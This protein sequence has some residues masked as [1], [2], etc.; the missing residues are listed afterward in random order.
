M[1]S[2]LNLRMAFHVCARANERQKV[3]RGQREALVFR[4]W[5]LLRAKLRQLAD[6]IKRLARTEVAQV[7]KLRG[8][9][10]CRHKV[11]HSR[12]HLPG[13]S[14]GWFSLDPIGLAGHRTERNNDVAA[15]GPNR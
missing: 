10:A 1:S 13:R 14:G 12:D 2:G 8:A 4:V 11:G 3:L 5:P 7:D 9:V 15:P 6:A